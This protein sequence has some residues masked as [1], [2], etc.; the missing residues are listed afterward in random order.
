M[1]EMSWQIETLTDYL[2]DNF[3]EEYNYSVN[4]NEA[5]VDMVV[6]VID[7]LY[8]KIN[9]LESKTKEDD[10]EQVRNEA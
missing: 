7:T 5:L 1:C 8:A 9:E 10:D 4:H 6:R 2:E 3:P